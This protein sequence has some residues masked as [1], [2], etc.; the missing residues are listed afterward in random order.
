MSRPELLSDSDITARLATTYGW[1][2]TGETITKSFTFAGFP[3]AVA[4][5]TRLVAPAERLE[6][7]P[8]V[9][10]RFNRVDIAL[11]TH[12]V[13][14]VTALDFTLADEIEKAVGG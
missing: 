6:H 5:V 12:E 14:G 9:N 10:L 4:F 3:G 11:S 2:R 8:D 13:G 7:H 1:A